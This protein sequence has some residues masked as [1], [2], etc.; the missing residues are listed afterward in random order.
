IDEQTNVLVKLNFRWKLH[1]SF[2]F[3]LLGCG[4][5]GGL[6]GSVVPGA[7]GGCFFR[8]C[9]NSTTIFIAGPAIHELRSP[10]CGYSSFG[11]VMRS[12]AFGLPSFVGGVHQS[13]SSS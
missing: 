1:C 5:F 9:S 7:I 4:K 11:S 2:G 6:Y 10:V 12:N 13:R 3:S 8:L